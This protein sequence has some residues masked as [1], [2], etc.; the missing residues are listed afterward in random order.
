M[1]AEILTCQV[2]AVK[3]SPLWKLEQNCQYN[4]SYGHFFS[5]FQTCACTILCL[6][7]KAHKALQLSWG[8]ID[9]LNVYSST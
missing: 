2:N 4:D 7:I 5:C 3:L 8:L 6:R 9:V 1:F